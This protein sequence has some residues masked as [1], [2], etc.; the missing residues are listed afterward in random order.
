MQQKDQGVYYGTKSCIHSRIQIANGWEML[1]TSRSVKW[2][3]CGLRSS[4]EGQEP[5]HWMQGNGKDDTEVLKRKE[6]RVRL[7]LGLSCG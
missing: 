1:C 6:F 3:G 7:R 4:S 5:V 2:R